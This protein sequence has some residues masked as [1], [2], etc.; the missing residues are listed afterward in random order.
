MKQIVIRNPH[1]FNDGKYRPCGWMPEAE[2]AEIPEGMP[3]RFKKLHELAQTPQYAKP[4]DAGM[5]LVA[6]SKTYSDLYI[7]YGTG[8]DFEIPEGYVGL[9]FPRSSA[10]NYDLILSNCVGVV[11]S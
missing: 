1:K 8:L 3:V 6:I 2:L 9:L 7:E 10:S 5:D 4:T 11:D